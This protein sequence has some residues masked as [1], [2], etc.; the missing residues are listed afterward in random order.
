[1]KK[2]KRAE[3]LVYDASDLV[4]GIR[5]HLGV[6]QKELAKIVKVSLSS[7]RQIEAANLISYLK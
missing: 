1:M 7:I 3:N 6:S 2:N 4:S 5:M